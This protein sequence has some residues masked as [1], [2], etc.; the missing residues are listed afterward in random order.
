M[1][2]ESAVI[3]EF[4]K[5]ME[6]RGIKTSATIVPDGSIHRIHVDGDRKGSKN[7]WYIL[8]L[9]GKPAGAFGCCRRYGHREK[10]TWTAKGVRKLTPDERRAW[11]EDL[12]RRAA[13]KEAARRAEHAAAAALA[14]KIW[15]AARACD[16]DA[17]PYLQRKGVRSHGLRVGVWEKVN[18]D[19]GEI[20]TVS[21]EAL[22]VPIRDAGKRIH[23]LQAILPGKLMSGR[24]RDKDYLSKGAKEGLFYAIGK[25]L[26]HDGRKV[27]LVGEGYATVASLHEHTGHAGVVAFDA[28]NLLPVAKT[29][30]ARFPDA[31]IILAADNDQWTHK[32]IANPGVHHA[33]AAAAAV[34]GLVIIPDLPADADGQPSDFNDLLVLRGPQA[35]REAVEHALSPPPEPTPAEPEL[36]AEPAQP[37]DDGDDEDDDEPGSPDRNGHFA[38][39]G[40]D[41]GTYYI[42]VHG[43]GQIREFTKG[44]FSESGLIEMAP[45][46]WWEAHFPTDKGGIDKKAAANFI[47]RTAERRG[48]YDVSRVRGRGAWLDDG[49]I[50]Y[51]HGSSLSVD[52]QR[53]GVTKIASRYVY[54]LHQPLPEPADEPLSSEDGEHILEVASMFRWHK[55]GSAALLAGWVALAP[56]CGALKWRPHIWLRGGAGSGKS[57]VLNNYVNYLCGG[58]SLF[59]QGNSSEAGVRQTLKTDALPVLFDESESNEEADAR[60]IQAVLSMIRQA[61]TESQA[62][63]LKGTAGGEAMKFHIRS[64]FCLASI[65][66]ALKQQADVERMTVLDLRSKRDDPNPAEGWKRLREALYSLERDQDL[67]ARLFRRS[68]DLLPITLKNVLVFSEAAA[69]VFGS[70]RDGDQYGTLLAG[71]WSL[72]STIEASREDALEMIR[73]YDW[74]E[75]RETSEVD[76]AERVI[77]ALMEAKIRMAGG[78]ELNVYELVCAAAGQP[79]AS[80]KVEAGVSDAAL[81][82]HGMRVEGGLLLLSNTSEALKGLVAHTPFAADLR[83]ALLR[84]PGVE[85]HVKPMRF[86]GAM[87]RC[88]AVPL[89]LV[90]DEDDVGRQRGGMSDHAYGR[91]GDPF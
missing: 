85:R 80:T 34:D 72:I 60:R 29:I 56:L 25:P 2:H 23:S 84:T 65:Q 68:L 78:I 3:D 33:R 9:D 17:H 61:S 21:R 53:M 79:L 76:E 73:R 59:A 37:G 32:P 16:G 82:R 24:T 66:V 70:Q 19:T 47:V 30:R 74:S 87:S 48:I 89:S 83:G 91:G 41:H 50:V 45:L 26:E 22:L 63:T 69:S 28:A 57:T 15:E 12:R 5:A 31:I 43:Q 39:L 7:G 8:H 90:L 46:N 54:E 18:E 11:A 71:A 55:P 10:F 51:H 86:S 35:L 27:I 77:S 42:F 13:E 58:G 64:M 49:R 52:G 4:L 20:Y 75:H 81:Q 40:Y 1:V 36:P 14:N 67:P 44:D 88:I 38:I 6:E 62:R